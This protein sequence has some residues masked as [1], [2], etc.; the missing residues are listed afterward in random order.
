MREVSWFV[1]HERLEVELP[2][3]YVSLGT[4]VSLAAVYDEFIQA[5]L[6]HL[7]ESGA[8]RP[9]ST[10]KRRRVQPLWWS[11]ECEDKIK[12][13]RSCYK[14]YY[15][16]QSA[17]GKAVFK[18]VDSEVKI[19]LRGQKSSSFWAFCESL[20]PSHGISRIW[21]TLRALSSR[22][23][24]LR[25]NFLTDLNSAEF[26]K[27]RDELVR[28]EV[29]LADIPLREVGVGGVHYAEPFTRR[30]FDSAIAACR[31]KSAAGLDE[32]PYVILRKFSDETGAFL[33]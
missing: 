12:E 4:G 2:R 11:R 15:R 7:L 8:T 9:D 28:G 26:V 29:P 30:E 6:R 3:L 21:S 33:L 1:F 18:K 22:T 24:A 19:F 27:L 17:D 14:V 10:A 5:V 25:T 13:R 23:G 31:A 20:D 16:D 32:V